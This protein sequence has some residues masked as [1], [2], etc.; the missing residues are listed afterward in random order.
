MPQ[1]V[2]MF[3]TVLYTSFTNWLLD[4]V[5]ITILYDKKSKQD[6]ELPCQESL[7]NVATI[8]ARTKAAYTCLN[9]APSAQLFITAAKNVR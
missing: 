6:I 1:E 8:R 7:G 2:R 3:P 5:I 4:K 9:I